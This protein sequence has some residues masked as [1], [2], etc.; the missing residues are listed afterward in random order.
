MEFALTHLAVQEIVNVSIRYEIDQSL[1]SRDFLNQDLFAIDIPLT[2]EV[3]RPQR[4][5]CGSRGGLAGPRS[6]NHCDGTTINC[7]GACMQRRNA[8]EPQYK[9]HYRAYQIG[10]RVFC[11]IAVWPISPNLGAIAMNCEP[12]SIAIEKRNVISIFE[13]EHA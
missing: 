4:G 11:G 12:R 9:S 5:Q 13:L 7:H 3:N 6:T 1:G 2:Q 10:C 8:F